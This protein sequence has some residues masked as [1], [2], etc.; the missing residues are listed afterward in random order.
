MQKHPRMADTMVLFGRVLDARGRLTEA[1]QQL[2]AAV[3]IHRGVSP[4]GSPSLATALVT[5]G[6]VMSKTR[7]AADAEPLLREALAFRRQSLPAG[8]RGVGDAEAALAECLLQQS[9]P[10]EVGALLESAA[11]TAPPG[12]TS[13]L[14]DQKAVQDLLSRVKATSRG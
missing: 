9:K 14:Y 2:T 3:A 12:P 13:L 11:K 4:K 5:L 7:R 1:E 6:H 8:H 10:T